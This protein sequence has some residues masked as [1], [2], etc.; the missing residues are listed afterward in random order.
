[1]EGGAEV[2]DECGQLGFTEGTFCLAEDSAF[3]GPEN[4][5]FVFEDEGID[6][7]S[8]GLGI[9]DRSCSTDEVICSGGDRFITIGDDLGFEIFD[10]FILGFCE[11]SVSGF[12]F[13]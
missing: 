9:N 13:F 12:V 4:A 5:G 1:M 10:K 3:G 6:E 2:F 8:V 11:L 7:D